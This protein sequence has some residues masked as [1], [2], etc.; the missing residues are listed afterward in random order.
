MRRLQFIL[1]I[2]YKNECVIPGK[3]EVKKH[4]HERILETH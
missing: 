4:E 3:I 2:N 1:E